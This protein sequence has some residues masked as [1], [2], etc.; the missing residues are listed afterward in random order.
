MNSCDSEH[1]ADETALTDD[2]LVGIVE[3]LQ[4]QGNHMLAEPIAKIIVEVRRARAVE[5]RFTPNDRG[6]SSYDKKLITDVVT[7]IRTMSAAGHHGQWPSAADIDHSALL[8]RIRAGKRPL[9]EPPPKSFSYPWYALMEPGNESIEQKCEVAEMEW[10]HG[11]G[12]D[13]QA[14][15]M[16]MLVINQSLWLIQHTLIKNKHYIATFRENGTPF[17]VRYV[18]GDGVFK[19]RIKRIDAN[20]VKALTRDVSAGGR[21]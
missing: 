5:K 6:L 17:S 4:R 11:K 8:A 20:I 13:G 2:E 10:E 1:A 9:D 14:L 15:Q 7:W 12:F 16:T 18:G 3:M 19:W 21:E